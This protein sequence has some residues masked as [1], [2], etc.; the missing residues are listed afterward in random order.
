MVIL[1]NIQMK[2][3]KILSL[4]LFLYSAVSFAI[5]SSEPIDGNVM[6]NVSVNNNDGKPLEREMILLISSKSKKVY[7]YFTDA[8]GKFYTLIPL[9]DDYDVIYKDFMKEIKYGKISVPTEMDWYVIEYK[10]TFESSKII[11]LEN[12][13]Y[14]FKRAAF[15]A[16]SYKTLHY[17]VDWMRLRD[18][19]KIEIAGHTYSR[20]SDEHN[21]KIS[22]ELADTARNYLISRGIKADRII[23][24]GY[25]SKQ[26]IDLNTKPGGSDNSDGRCRRKKKK[27]ELRI[28]IR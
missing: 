23:A 6:L 12:V 14:N 24:T 16:S 13:E 19:V 4:L 15:L 22:Q 11:V 28:I 25:G 2:K 27:A 1:N 20:G 21:I 7:T 8:E 9:D 3:I 17:L 26:L 5:G 10:M 18:K